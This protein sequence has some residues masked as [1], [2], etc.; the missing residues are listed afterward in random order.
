MKWLIILLALSIK[1]GFVFLALVCY[2]MWCTLCL[3]LANKISPKWCENFLKFARD[4]V[5]IIYYKTTDLIKTNFYLHGSGVLSLRPWLYH[6]FCDFF[7]DKS[8]IVLSMSSEI[9]ISLLFQI[10]VGNAYHIKVFIKKIEGKRC[11]IV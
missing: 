8:H 5:I 11:L 6:L 2:V 1:T 3:G 7:F 9:A 10:F 4:R